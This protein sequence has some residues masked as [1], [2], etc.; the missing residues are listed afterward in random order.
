MSGVSVRASAAETLRSVVEAPCVERCIE[1]ERGE[2]L[3]RL[4]A[5]SLG[6]RRRRGWNDVR[7]EIV[8][9]SLARYR[10]EHIFVVVWSHRVAWRGWKVTQ[11]HD[12][13]TFS[14]VRC[15]IGER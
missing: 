13:S 4:S 14:A 10:R 5:A 9:R 8:R 3:A 11:G 1:P 2:R 12:L 7:K 15:T 6:R